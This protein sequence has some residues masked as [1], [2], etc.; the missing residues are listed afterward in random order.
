MAVGRKVN[1]RLDTAERSQIKFEASALDDLLSE[2]H[3]ARQVWGYV[4]GLDLSVLYDRVRTT[5]TS[6]GRPAID[7]AVLMA[8][9]LYATVEGIGSA[10]LLDRKCRSDAAYRWLAGGVSVNYHTLADFRTAVGPLLDRLLSGSMTSLI[11]AKIV[12]VSALAV[13]GVRVH[14]SAGRRSLRRGAR[15]EALHQE[16]EQTVS[17][18]RAE[19]EEDPGAASRREQA[20]RQAVAKDRVRRLEKARQAHAEIEGKRVKE[21]KE[22]RR[23]K[24]RADQKEARASTSDPQARVMKMGDGSY[25]PAYNIQFKTTVDGQHVVGV[26]VTNQGSD[27]GILGS[28]LEEIEDRYGVKPSRVLADGGYNSK[29]DIER[30]HNSGIEMF[31]PLP[32]PRK[33]GLDPALPRRG[34][35]PGVVIWRQRMATPEAQATYRKRFATER[36]HAHMRNHGLRQLCVRGIEKVKAIALWHVHAFNFLQFN[37]LGWI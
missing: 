1:L 11:E 23:K 21:V 6:S 14:A 10:R 22:Q 17:R 20:R 27:R 33:G 28:A 24:K 34:D 3:L 15:L 26:S 4:E 18:L 19:L 30:L 25:R 16:A 32:K 36:P 13:D 5:T 37:R 29:V 7:P 9:W 2:D 8:L 31:C 12:D 35:K